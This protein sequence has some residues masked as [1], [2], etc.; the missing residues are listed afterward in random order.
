VV[1]MGMG[2]EGSLCGLLY[3]LRHWRVQRLCLSLS[4]SLSLSL[5]LSLSLFLFP[6][7]ILLVLSRSGWPAMAASA[8]AMVSQWEREKKSVA[9][10]C[11]QFYIYVHCHQ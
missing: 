11:I 8:P 4:L 10:I 5:T 9:K 1:R 7:R 6:R 3:D 2:S